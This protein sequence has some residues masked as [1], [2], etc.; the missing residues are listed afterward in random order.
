MPVNMLPSDMIAQGTK[1]QFYVYYNSVPG[2][3]PGTLQIQEG[4]NALVELQVTSVSRD[5][6]SRVASQSQTEWSIE[7]IYLNSPISV[8]QFEADVMN[9]F[10]SFLG[11]Y[12]LAGFSLQVG[13]TNNISGDATAPSPDGAQGESQ[14][15]LCANMGIGCG[16]NSGPGGNWLCNTFGMGCDSA[17]NWSTSIG[18][19]AIAAIV[20]SVIYFVKGVRVG[21]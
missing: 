17:I 13:P 8:G 3:G 21:A 4:L 5:L 10:N 19:I 12:G 7:G 16:D 2:F 14:S 20:I 11:D 18:L 15:W 6:I 9:V 1:L